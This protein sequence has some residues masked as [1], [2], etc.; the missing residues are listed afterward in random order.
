M[1]RRTNNQSELSLD[2]LRERVRVLYTFPI[3]QGREFNLEVTGKT[4][5][6]VQ[7]GLGRAYTGFLAMNTTLGVTEANT[8]APN[9]ELNLTISSELSALTAPF[10]LRLWVF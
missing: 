7:H 3:F 2:E 4:S 9:T 1:A 8:T 6:R 10:K 5:I